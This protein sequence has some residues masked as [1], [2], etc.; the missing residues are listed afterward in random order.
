MCLNTQKNDLELDRLIENHKIFSSEID[1]Q[2]IRSW[3]LLVHDWQI[4][5]NNSN[6]PKVVKSITKEKP[7]LILH[8]H[9]HTEAPLWKEK[10]R[11]G[12]LVFTRSNICSCKRGTPIARL[13]AFYG[14]SSFTHENIGL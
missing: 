1:T 3:V 11:L 13:I 12:N 14:L 2:K 7:L 6:F 9:N 5:R 4:C 8:G 10:E